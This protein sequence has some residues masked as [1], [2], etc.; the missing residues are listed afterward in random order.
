[1]SDERFLGTILHDI[2][3]TNITSCACVEREEAGLLGGGEFI[4][5]LIVTEGRKV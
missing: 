5:N 4:D 3:A 2:S 1:V